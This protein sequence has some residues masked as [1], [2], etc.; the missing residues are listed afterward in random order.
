M[1][2]GK[3]HYAAIAPSPTRQ[4]AFTGVAWSGNRGDTR[5]AYVQSCTM[6]CAPQGEPTPDWYGARGTVVSITTTE[7][8]R[9]TCENCK[10]QTSVRRK[11]CRGCGTLRY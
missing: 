2:P 9:W 8:A 6:G 4:V 11:R 7:Q 1:T 3:P 10:Q 5:A